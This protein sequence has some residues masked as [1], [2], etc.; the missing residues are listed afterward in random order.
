MLKARLLTAVALLVVFLAAMLL[1]PPILWAALTLVLSLIGFNEWA[2]LYG[3]QRRGRA[4]YLTFTFLFGLLLMWM[5]GSSADPFS[6]LLL[7]AAGL[8]WVV[9]A[10]LW[11]YW[12]WRLPGTAAGAL[13]GWLLLFAFWVALVGLQSDRP[14]S[15]LL[16]MAVVWISDTAAYFTGRAFGKHKLAPAISPGKSWEGVAGALAAVAVY[17]LLLVGVLHASAW[18]LLF[19][20]V[21]AIL[22]IIGDLFESLLKRQANVKDSGA[23]LPGHGGLLDRVD[24]LLPTLPVAALIMLGLNMGHL[25]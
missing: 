2:R 8:F 19:F 5:L 20:P 15:L 22:G 21:L 14:A 7:L 23:L 6:I 11:L 3:M 4:M 24:A 12:K 1:L 9:I 17:A 13:L 16:V 10:P 25:I 18:L